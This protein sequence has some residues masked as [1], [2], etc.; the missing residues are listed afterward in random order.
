MA[1]ISALQI[2]LIIS[3]FLIIPVGIWNQRRRKKQIEEM[4]NYYSGSSLSNQGKG[5]FSNEK[6]KNY[7]VQYKDSYSRESIKSALVGAGNSEEEV[8]KY[9]VE[10]FD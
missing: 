6:I 8:E 5:D 7:V 4:S 2:I 1:E 9:L 3:L 10:F